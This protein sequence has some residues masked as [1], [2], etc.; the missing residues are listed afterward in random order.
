MGLSR[1]DNFLKSS[2]GTILY[3]NP[4]DL[5]STDSIENQGNSMTRPFKTIQRA[6][7]EAA[8]FSYQRGLNND[9]FGKTTILIYPGDH[10]VDNRPGFI[11]DGTNNF[12]LRNGTVTNDLQDYNLISNFDVNSVSNELY[13]LNSIHGGVIVPRGTSIVGLDLRKTKIRPKYIPDPLNDNIER[14]ALFRI[15][16]AGYFWQ[17]SVFDANPNAPAYKDY[18]T[19]T[20]IPNYSHH[21]L[22]CFEYADGVNPVNI[23]DEFLTYSSTRT[24]LD[25][26]Y[27]KVSIVYG[28][29]SGRTI[30]PEYPSV[31]IDI[32]KKIDEYRIVGSIGESVGI[33]SIRAG[34]GVLSSSTITVTTSEPLDNLEVDTPFRIENVTAAGY[35][36]QY[37]VFDKTSDTE[38]TFK[39]NTIPSNPL[40]NAT[41]AVL[42]LSSDTV[43]SASP[44]IFNV[45]L[46][47]VFGM[48][49]MHA[50]GSKA[51]GFRS[52]VVAQ[53][54]GIGLNK[55]DNAF[56]IFNQDTPSTGNYDDS[57]SAGNSTISNNSRA[58]YK[59]D[60]KNVHIRCSNKS[61]IQVV[62][63][64]AIGFGEQFVTESGGDM[65]L[66]NSNSNFGAVALASDGFRTDAFTQDDQGYITHVVPPE[67]LP[68]EENSIEFTSID[69][70]K[71]LPPAYSGVGVGTTSHLFLYNETNPDVLPENIIEGYRVGAKTNDTLNFLASINGS[72]EQ[73]S[74]R[75]TMP[76]PV[77]AARTDS[78]EKVFKVARTSAGINQ[79]GASS[80]GNITNVL[81]LEE[82][83]NF[84]NGESVRVLSSTGQLPDGLVPDTVYFVIT[85]ST[86]I[87]NSRPFNIKLAQS[88]NDATN[89]I[90]ININTK[91]GELRINSRV[92]DKVPGE[93]GHP[94]QY[95]TTNNQW[96]VNVSAA[97]TENTIFPAIV[98]LGSTSLGNST[99]RTFINRKRDERSSFDK[100]YHV[101]Y[102]IPKNSVGVS[103]PPVEGFVLQDTCGSLTTQS[104]VDTFFGSGSLSNSNDHRNM[105]FISEGT[106]DSANGRAI[107][108]TEVPHKLRVGNTVAIN[109]VKSSNNLNS[110]NN[111][112]FNGTFAVTGISSAKSFTVGLSTNPGAFQNNTNLRNTVLPRFCRKDFDRG[113]YYTYRIAERQKYLRAEQDGIYYLTLIDASIKPTVAPFTNQKFSQPVKSLF[114]QLRRDDPISDPDPAQSHVRSSLIGQVDISDKRHSITRKAF[115]EYSVDSNIGSDII[116]MVSN[117][118]GTAHTITTNVDHGYNSIIKLSIVD[119]G[120]NYGTG[121]VTDEIFYNAKITNSDSNKV[122]GNFAT[123]KVTVGTSGSI[124]QIRIMDGGSAY[125]IGNTVTVSG[126]STIANH[127]PAIFEVQSIENRVGEVLKVSGIS[128]DSLKN[129]NE[130][131]RITGIT[132]G[133]TNE[134]QVAS[135]STISG[136]VTESTG[137]G[138][139]VLS[140]AQIQPT[141]KISIVSSFSYDS[142]TGSAAVVS[143]GPHGFS[144]GQKIRLD[145]AN[146][147]LYNGSFVIT[148]VNDNLN[149]PSY[150][151]TINVGVGTIAPTASGTQIAYPEG[152]SSNKG[153]IT[154]DDENFGGRQVENYAGITT[155]ISVAIDTLST[156][157][158]RIAGAS[159]YN[160]NIGDYFQIDDE[161][162][163]VRSTTATSSISGISNSNALQDNDNITVF[164]GVLGT[165]AATHPLHSTIK[166][167]N[168]L[169][170]EF[171]RHSIIRASGH[172]FEYV[173]YGP[174]NYSTAFPDKQDREITPE[175]E[176][177]SQSTKR[178]GG[179]NFYTG[180][181]DKGISYSGNKRLSTITGREEIFDTPVET[182]EGEDILS[183]SSINVVSAVESNLS[184]SIK[185]DGGF[186]KEAISEFNGPVIVSNK[187]T[188][189]SDKGVESNNI[190]LQGDTSVSRKYTVGLGTP[191]LSGNPGDLVFNANPVDGGNAGWVYTLSNQ[192]RSFGTIS[193]TTST[194]EDLFERVGIGTTTAGVNRL[195]VLGNENQFSVDEVGHVGIGTTANGYALNVIGGD[196]FIDDDF[197]IGAGLTVTGQ[198]SVNDGPVNI[199]GTVTNITGVGIHSITSGTY[200]GLGVSIFSAGIGETVFYYGD[201]SNLVNLNADQTGWIRQGNNLS[202]EDVL[203]G[204]VGIGTSIPTSG[205]ATDFLLGYSLT[206]GSAVPG[207]AGTS[208]HV[209]DDTHI[210]G[211]LIVDTHA[212]VSGVSTL[213]GP[214]RITSSSDGYLVGTALTVTSSNV[215]GLATCNNVF[216]SG[217]TTSDSHTY[218]RSF[219][220]TNN[221]VTQSGGILTLDLSTGQNFEVTLAANITEI[222]LTNPPADSSAMSF[223][224]KF[225]Q[226]SNAFYTI[227]LDDIRITPFAESNRVTTKWPGQVVP[228]MSQAVN[229]I[230]IYSFKTFDVSNLNT[231]GL[232]GVIGGQNFA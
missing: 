5:D 108:Q 63:C 104:E 145:G 193:L 177:L 149:I 140:D 173:G 91:G 52:M 61:I 109:Q 31:N 186:N 119:G 229:A 30:S 208:L 1:L 112:G 181:N 40:P 13:K 51:T 200:A 224:V 101:R 228:V 79:I 216:I 41:G 3:V 131:Y 88:L 205:T 168:V 110:L 117:A 211:S 221:S 100:L 114:P 58:R 147:A 165:K 89:D 64:F 4:N 50:D 222:R 139:I 43:T 171:R 34:D 103:R 148:E 159:N 182:V 196:V 198:F 206:V 19:N 184:R 202:Y 122:V 106:W 115:E 218:L 158:I 118:A 84:F 77:G 120:T 150:G 141:G 146:Q 14:T 107:F 73:Y 201:G 68:I 7:I 12:R 44:Y 28:E 169:P 116:N 76:S 113:V 155:T 138:S 69:V 26:Y 199:G 85:E 209:H 82:N 86:D 90:P 164:R 142:T 188:V 143:S 6:L 125:G 151:Y 35:D 60:W 135:A 195:Q 48:N 93:F 21:K 176:L 62:S 11:P 17:F 49:G 124:T 144:V 70:L 105:R 152:Y 190:F 160:I 215:T 75:I 67:E 132:T 23:S 183:L 197:V 45:S 37:V 121:S 170:V 174:G 127:T 154:A 57:T 92:S 203:N 25:M 72:L 219:S 128:S 98:G 210:T 55:D 220:E 230:D 172:T 29:Q 180:M 130:L 56:V 42:T 187:L 78:G 39:G 22:T 87:P 94:I 217:I 126:I 166:R 207:V 162:V 175:E 185:V 20:F 32:E 71:T 161:I 204:R 136:A 10:I 9:R 111:L 167:I 213:A 24:D 223:T 129:Y 65:S 18:T 231:S 83:H 226:P 2:K 133:A 54:T 156:N 53:F 8:R 163:R 179:I 27:E 80:V 36:G 192:W 123:A 46:R 66:T 189:R 74:A 81:T 97:A 232:Y 16:G 59:P 102:V 157:I 214:Y 191:S 96:Y 99:P 33:S 95:D 178:A 47:S 212:L 225:T 38:I 227:D 137:L 153:V 194:K 15:T 134:I